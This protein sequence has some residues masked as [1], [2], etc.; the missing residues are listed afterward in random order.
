MDRIEHRKEI[1]EAW[2]YLASDD[3]RSAAGRILPVDGG[4]MDTYVSE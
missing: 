1:A 4:A 2:V 3:S